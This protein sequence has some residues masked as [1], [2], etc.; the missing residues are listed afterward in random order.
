M[1]LKATPTIITVGCENISHKGQVSNKILNELCKKATGMNACLVDE[2]NEE[3]QII[4]FQ[5]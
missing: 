4:I 5:F 3:T 2:Q 1:C